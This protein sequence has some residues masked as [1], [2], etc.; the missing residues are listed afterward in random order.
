MIESVKY[1][2]RKLLAEA[3]KHLV[4]NKILFN[5]EYDQ[6]LEKA[7]KENEVL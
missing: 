2:E 6:R 3:A 5:K 7:N 4:D 1:K